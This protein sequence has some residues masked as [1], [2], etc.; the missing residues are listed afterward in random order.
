MHEGQRYRS[1]ADRLGGP[2]AASKRWSLSDPVRSLTRD[3]LERHG[4]SEGQYVVCFPGVSGHADLRRWR[5]PNFVAVLDRLAHERNL[6][7]VL[8]GST[9]ERSDLDRIARMTSN[10]SVVFPAEPRDLALTAGLLA[11]AR[12][13]LG[14]DSGP[15]HLAQALGVAGVVIFGGG[16]RPANYA[17]WGAGSIG[18]LHPLPCFGCAWD[19]IL[20]YGLCVDSVPLSAVADAMLRV[21]D[22]RP[23][24]PEMITLDTVDSRLKDML[25]QANSRYRDVQSDRDR[26]LAVIVEMKARIAALEHTAAERLGMIEQI[27]AEAK[28]REQLIS[29][30]DQAVAARDRVAAERLALLETVH[31]EAERQ[32]QVIA[33][34]TDCL[35]TPA[36]SSAGIRAAA[37]TSGPAPINPAHE[38]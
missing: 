3:W 24:G 27:H 1:L 20:E 10:P 36:Q 13:Y 38:S 37:Q 14:N 34:L 9:D 8:I 26:R 12:V 4:L 22:A 21:L 29:E 23:D 25:G 2:T 19:C 5:E 16:G 30:L 6:S 15:A 17:C 18:V 31:A 32:R 7:A 11:L 28:R 33:E 35:A